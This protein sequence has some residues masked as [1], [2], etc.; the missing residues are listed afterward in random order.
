SIFTSS[1]TGTVTL[2]GFIPV[3]LGAALTREY[4]TPP[5]ERYF[6]PYWTYAALAM[7][8]GVLTFVYA[9]PMIL[10]E[11]L[12]PGGPNPT[13]LVEILVL[14]FISIWWLATAG[15]TTN[16]LRLEAAEGPLSFCSSAFG[17][18]DDTCAKK[19]GIAA[20]GFLNWLIL[21]GYIVALIV[22]AV[23]ATSRKHTRVWTSSVA[24]LPFGRSLPAKH[25]NV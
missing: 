2:F 15:E 9:V 20:F 10:L 25:G 22:F 16:I 4:L 3:G 17:N 8:S 18:G 21:T 19:R 13:I 23:K 11:I 14:G 24:N 12:R 6:S 5:D 7:A 1:C